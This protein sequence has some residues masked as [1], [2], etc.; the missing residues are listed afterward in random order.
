MRTHYMTEL[1]KRGIVPLQTPIEVPQ[2]NNAMSGE[3]NTFPMTDFNAPFM[4]FG[5]VEFM[6]QWYGNMNAYGPQRY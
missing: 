1:G 5:G 6:P 4:D 3:E 2:V